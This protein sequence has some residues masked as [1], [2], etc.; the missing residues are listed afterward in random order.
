MKQVGEY[1]TTTILIVTGKNLIEPSSG[2]M[3]PVMNKREK[4]NNQSCRVILFYCGIQ[5]LLNI[6]SQPK[7]VVTTCKLSGPDFVK[8]ARCHA[9]EKSLGIISPFHDFDW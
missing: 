3:F 6:H 9:L 7:H 1:N 4:C 2:V 8:N 5:D